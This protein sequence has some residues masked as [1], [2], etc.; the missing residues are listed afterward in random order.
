MNWSLASATRRWV[1]WRDP[2][3]ASLPLVDPETGLQCL[4]SL[5][6]AAETELARAA[7][8]TRPVVLLAIAPPPG[9]VTRHE[10]QRFAGS[11]RRHTRGFDLIGRDQDGGFVLLLPE[12]SRHDAE[13]V[14]A[15]IREQAA[16]LLQQA[17][18]AEDEA[19]RVGLAVF[20]EQGML[21]DELLAAA[22]ATA[23]R[24]AAVAAVPSCQPAAHDAAALDRFVRIVSLT[25]GCVLAASLPWLMS[26]ELLLMILPFIVLGIIAERVTNLNHSGTSESLG[27]IAI[28]A[29]GA[30]GGPA[31]GAVTGCIAGLADWRVN[32]RPLNKGLFNA[33]NLTL[34]GAAAGLP[35][36]WLGSPPELGGSPLI[37]VPG[38]VA[39]L[40]CFVTSMV[41]LAQVVALASG[42]RFVTEWRL[43]CN[44]LAV[45]SAVMGAISLG[46][47][48]LYQ[49][50]GLT[51]LLLLLGPVALIYYAQ[52][53]Y[54]THTAAHVAELSQLNRDL[55]GSNQQLTATNERLATTLD[56]LRQANDSMLTALCE[57]LELRDQETEGH[58]QRVVRYARA[59]A[60][61]L[62]LTPDEV[63]AVVHGAHLHDIGKIGVADAILRKPGPLT[64]DEW[65][66]MKR[67]PELGYQM[68]QHIPFLA[69]AAVLVR[70]H[71]EHWNGRGYPAGLMG[72]TIPIGARIFA[73]VDSFDAMTSD[74]PYR[75]AMAVEIALAELLRNSGSQYDPDIV[76]VFC[77]MVREGALPVEAGLDAA[78]LASTLRS[79]VTVRSLALTTAP[80][81]S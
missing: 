4:A 81:L 7:R 25:G 13:T 37:L 1:P 30:L 24:A 61:A 33:G 54:I 64:P 27:S 15:R 8:F 34:S 80:S 65:I 78:E 41:L 38:L 20:P 66:E 74:R 59:L 73:V 29:A 63:Q 44:W 70:Y 56:D 51:G 72:T 52:R 22:R 6:A 28:M 53:Q 46:I 9:A 62:S 50:Y 69:P 60:L 79:P 18:S 21:L 42:S 11:L 58:S 55:T 3:A 19:L 10:L 67:H 68:V 43:R 26:A 48:L 40:L 75:K 5:R 14:A 17:A 77:R 16:S 39:G 36:L 2:A 45:Y 12:T 57:A 31:A 32:A 49:S 47:A 35:Y 71:H 76:A 23:S